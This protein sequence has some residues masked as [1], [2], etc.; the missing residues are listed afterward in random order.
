MIDIRELEIIEFIKK[1]DKTFQVVPLISEWLCHSNRSM[2]CHSNRSML[3]H[4][5]RSKLCH[6][7]RSKLCRFRLQ[8]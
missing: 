7:N 8:M 3:C 2:L 5:N 1:M 6:L 4:L